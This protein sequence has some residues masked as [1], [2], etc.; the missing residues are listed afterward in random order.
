[1]QQF[2]PAVRPFQSGTIRRVAKIPA[3]LSILDACCG[4]D[5]AFD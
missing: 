5:N 2:C 3:M 4:P 1:M